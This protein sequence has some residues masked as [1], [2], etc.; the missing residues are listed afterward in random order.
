MIKY[1]NTKK[2]E[3]IDNYFGDSVIDN[4]QWL[5]DDKSIDTKDWIDSQNDLTYNYLSKIPYREEIKEEIRSL[6]NYEKRSIPF[7]SGDYTYY[8]K[9]D[10]L[11]NQSLLYRVHNDDNKEELFIDPNTLSSDG[12]NSISLLEFSENGNFL[13]FSVSLAGSDW[14]KIYVMDTK[15]KKIIEELDDIKFSNI[16]WDNNDGFFYSTYEKPKKS[17][18]SEKT[19]E[20]RVYYH[21]LN[22]SKKEDKLIFPDDNTKHR[23]VSASLI[24][25]TNFLLISSANSTSGNK[26]YLKNLI[27]NSVIELID[28]YDYDIELIDSDNEY[29]YLLTNYMAANSKLVKAKISEPT[30]TKWETVIAES[31]NKLNVTTASKYFFANYTKDALSYIVC[32]DYK[33]N[34]IKEIKLDKKGTMLGFFAKKD[35]LYTYFSFQNY[36]TASRIYKLNLETLDYDLWWKPNLNF[37]EDEYISEQV[38]YESKDKT[39]IPLIITYKKGIKLDSSNPTILYGYGGFNIS[40]NP[41]FSPFIA[42]WL[43]KGYIYAVA[44]LRGGG[45]YGKNWHLAGIKLNKQNVFDDFIYAAK[46]LIKKNYTSSNFLAIRGGSNGGLLVGATMLQEPNLFKVALPAVGVLDML[47]YHKFTAGAGWAYDYGTSDDN[48]KMYEYL[49]AYSPVH[50]VKNYTNYP[51][52]LITTSDHDDR[53]VPAHSFKFAANLQENI[54]N[55]NPLLI[56]I[57]KNAGHG[58]GT[59]ISKLIEQYTDIY[60]FTLWNMNIK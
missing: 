47:R 27:D 29:L 22:T 18:L 50:N 45:E 53:V 35:S 11:Q 10:G 44:N 2:V 39:K 52:T 14:Q 31:E 1:P 57:E 26:L 9:N 46:Y 15:T 28:T 54:E 33:G 36:T 43:K 24:K 16:S 6:I 5:E 3:V 19:D 37:N 55:K 48:K 42:A 12:T 41:S 59:P 32:Y 23:Y 4:Y 20:H 49:K 8:F 40:L 38:F 21:K 60:A 56:R 34:I 58:A 17:E 30:Y 7:T 51:A 25:N 13:A